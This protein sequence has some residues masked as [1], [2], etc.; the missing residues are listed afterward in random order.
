MK[1]K[2]ILIG[3]FFFALLISCCIASGQT[4]EQQNVDYK[5]TPQDVIASTHIKGWQFESFERVANTYSLEQ[6]LLKTNLLS[7]LNDPKSSGLNQYCAIYY[8]GEL[9]ATEAVT[10]LAVKIKLSLN[11]LPVIFS[12]LPGTNMPSYL[13]MTALI[14]IGNPSIPAVIRNLAESDDAQV[15]ELSLQV[16]VKIDNDKDISILRLQKAIKAETDSQK[17]ARLQAALND[18][19]G[20]PIKP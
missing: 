16:I 7:I 10:S 17:Q 20:T 8:L 15:R 1:K 9:K 13:A 3:N 2:Y 11:D 5:I 14:K 4:N 12:H 18:L 19:T 6:G